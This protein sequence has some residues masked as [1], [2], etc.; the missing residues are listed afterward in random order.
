MTLDVAVTEGNGRPVTAVLTAKDFTVYEDG[1]PQ[2][3]SV[4]RAIDVPAEPWATPW[5]GNVRQDVITNDPPAGRL[6]AIIIDDA[7]LNGDESIIRAGRE[8]ARAFIDDLGPADRATI[9]FARDSRRAQPFTSDRERL[10]AAVDPLDMGFVG[11]GP[12]PTLG[13]G[14]GRIAALGDS[15]H[16]M[17]S[18]RTIEDTV[19][20]LGTSS[21]FPRALF[22]IGVGVRISW[23]AVAEPGSPGA[24]LAVQEL[25]RVY[26][27]RLKQILRDAAKMNIVVHTADPAGLS[28]EVSDNPGDTDF[29]LIL[30]RNTGGVAVDQFE[31]PAA[32]H[33]SH[34]GRNAVSLSAR[35][36]FP[37]SLSRAFA[38]LK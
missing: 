14:A 38:G 9:V 6:V 16:K 24:S 13:E 4:F 36:T 21:H 33:R 17:G 3:V 7:V 23:T 1:R 10:R 26:A 25:D 27:S 11:M 28:V 20:T 35:D 34:C 29:L 31:R 15:L 22:Y 37:T 8:N 18:L 12:S 2:A 30:S 19:K 5:M 32:R